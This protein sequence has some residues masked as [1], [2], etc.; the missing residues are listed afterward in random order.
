MMRS[1]CTFYD[2]AKRVIAESRL[3]EKKISLA[4]IEE[5]FKETLVY[6]LTRM[7]FKMPTTSPEELNKYFTDFCD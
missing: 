2:N 3:S 1:I 7:K 5:A 6:E 4:L